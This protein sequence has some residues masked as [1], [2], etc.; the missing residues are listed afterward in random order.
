MACFFNK[1]GQEARDIQTSAGQYTDTIPR[2][3]AVGAGNAA[4]GDAGVIVPYTMFKMYG[5]TQII[6]QMYE[7]ME[8]YMNWLN[9]RGF[10]G[11]G[12]AYCD[13]LAP[14]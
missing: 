14:N 9:S 3:A 6:S 12:T 11:A 10:E 4:W 2:S 8:K 1:S 7:S 13:W 5:D